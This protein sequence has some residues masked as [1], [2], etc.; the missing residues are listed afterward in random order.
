VGFQ[1]R[2]GRF[3]EDKIRC[4]FG[5]TNTGFLSSPAVRLIIIL[6]SPDSHNMYVINVFIFCILYLLDNI[7]NIFLFYIKICV[8]LQ[9]LTAAD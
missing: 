1:D 2:L 3:G 6:I 9:R 5:E 4:S 8:C 7:K